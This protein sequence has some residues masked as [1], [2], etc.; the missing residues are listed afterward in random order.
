MEIVLEFLTEKPRREAAK[1]MVDDDSASLAASPNPATES[2][3][4]RVARANI[5]DRV[6]A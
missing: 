5:E 3:A 1:A 4:A 6:D 2:S